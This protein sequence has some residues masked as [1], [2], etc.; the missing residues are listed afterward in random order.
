MRQIQSFIAVDILSLLDA[1]SL[2]NAEQVCQSWKEVISDANLWQKL[3][4]RNVTLLYLIHVI[5]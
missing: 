1:E 5:F 4:K 3:Y 2:K